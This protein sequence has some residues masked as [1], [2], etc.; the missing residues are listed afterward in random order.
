MPNKAGDKIKVYGAPWCGDCRR[1]KDY[2]DANKVPYEW[3]DVD[4]DPAGKA[5]VRKVNQNKLIIPTIVFP[6]GSVLVEPGNAE[7]ARKLKA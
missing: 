5:Y 7:L 6:D 1:S 2:L 4:Q 3:I